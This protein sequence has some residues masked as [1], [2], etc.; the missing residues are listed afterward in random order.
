MGTQLGHAAAQPPA[1]GSLGSSAALPGDGSPHVVHHAL[2]GL[3]SGP[4]STG[5][6]PLLRPA[7][8][9]APQAVSQPAMLMGQLQAAH[10]QQGHLG[11][12]AAAA[13]PHGLGQ[14][15]SMASPEQQH[16][17]GTAG[18]GLNPYPLVGLMGPDVPGELMGG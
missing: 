8:Q 12:E 15:V 9:L 17:W 14:P 4:L 16:A 18:M 5:A 13:G 3:A 1:A 2:S 6:L 10:P 7:P 11:W